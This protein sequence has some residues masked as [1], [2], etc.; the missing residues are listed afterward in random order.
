MAAST[1]ATTLGGSAVVQDPG[2]FIGALPT[3]PVGL[4]SAGDL[5]GLGGAGGWLPGGVAGSNVTPAAAAAQAGSST[6]QQGAPGSS[7][8]IVAAIHQLIAVSAAA[9]ARTGGSLG[10]ALNGVAQGAVGRSLY[11]TSAGYA[12]AV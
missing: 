3:G 11:N 6:S 2:S 5:T 12:G 4:G 1:S 7:G 8:D 10:L 9:P